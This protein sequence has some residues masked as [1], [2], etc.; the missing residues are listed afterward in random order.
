MSSICMQKSPVPSWPFLPPAYSS[1]IQGCSPPQPE[2]FWVS[3]LEHVSNIGA[4]NSSRGRSPLTA[5]WACRGTLFTLLR[6][7]HVL[8]A[9]NR[10]T[11][12][13]K[14]F[15]SGL[16][17]NFSEPVC[18]LFSSFFLLVWC[19]SSI[20]QE[21]THFISVTYHDGLVLQP[22]LILRTS[23]SQAESLNV[24]RLEELLIRCRWTAQ[25]ELIHSLQHFLF[26]LPFLATI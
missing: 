6:V 13:Y 22:W 8:P 17:N 21:T 24:P 14:L 25:E 15:H 16:W 19:Q 20:E 1:A 4:T 10:Q 5:S 18:H 11:L 7:T 9:K 12:W 3:Y 26:P 23:I 2:K